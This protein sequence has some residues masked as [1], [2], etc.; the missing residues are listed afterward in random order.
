MEESNGSSRVSFTIKHEH[1]NAA[2]LHVI[3]TE[4]LY[5]VL[6]YKFYSIKPMPKLKL[7]KTT[8][9]AK[10]LHETMYSALAEGDVRMLD[11]IACE[12]VFVVIVQ[13]VV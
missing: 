3:D 1:F 10:S 2:L 6:T 7:F 5:R 12:V 11:E 9:I 8:S 4:T 13:V